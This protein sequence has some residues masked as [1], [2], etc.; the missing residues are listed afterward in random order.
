MV[1][2]R[3]PITLQ[4][5]KREN[6]LASFGWHANPLTPDTPVTKDYRTTH[7]VRRFLAAQLD[8]EVHLE[9]PFMA[10]IRSGAPKNL[11]DVADELGRRRGRTAG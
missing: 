11:G 2:A 5:L 6:D 1:N 10:L 7:N 4:K 9:R 3:L 8:A